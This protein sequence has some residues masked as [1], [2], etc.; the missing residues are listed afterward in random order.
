MR[1][2]GTRAT[3]DRLLARIR[4]RVP[5]VALRTTVI[6]GF[7]GESEEDF[8]E[9]LDLLEEMRFD[10]V[11]A[12]TY[13]EEEGTVAATLPDPVPEALRR[14][15]LEEVMD[16]QRTI[17]FEANLE[18]VGRVDRLLVDRRLEGGERD[19]EFAAEGRTRGQAIDVDGVTHLVHAAPGAADR[20][21]PGTLLDVE[22][23]DALEYDLVARVLP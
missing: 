10:R 8:R 12:F 6:V 22:I 7:P 18:Q 21:V 3:Y 13:S 20:M 14:E 23:V 5:G 16:L 15:R 19:P 4:A 11:G 9:M 2:P 1:R 17:A